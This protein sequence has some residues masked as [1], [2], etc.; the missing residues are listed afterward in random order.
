MPGGFPLGLELAGS[1]GTSGP[2]TVAANAS[3]NTLGA[4][5]QIIASTSADSVTLL[6]CI[7]GFNNVGPDAGVDIGVGSAGNEVMVAQQLSV[8][9]KDNNGAAQGNYL[10][11]V[12]IPS[13]TRISAR[14][15]VNKINDGVK[16]AITTFDGAFTNF[17]GFAGVDPIGFSAATTLGTSVDPGAVLNTKGAY[18]QLIASTAK[19]YAGFII[20]FD[21]QNQLTG[22]STDQV[23]IGVDI[24]VGGAG[25][26][27]LLIPDVYLLKNNETY[28]TPAANDVGTIP[29][30][31]DVFWTPVPSGTRIAARARADSTTAVER[32][33]GVTV[34]GIYQ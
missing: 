3:I 9:R 22:I 26:E 4:W 11:P 13:G 5:V 17:D 20:A 30:N 34:Y 1:V 23:V 2:V 18:S 19:D 27:V 33:I 7:S 16:I 14:C 28:T 6:V 29:N 32:V 10:L 8:C 12:S 21:C 24:S 31:T 15:Q 25:S